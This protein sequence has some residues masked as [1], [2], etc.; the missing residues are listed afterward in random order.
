VLN[1][2][3]AVGASDNILELWREVVEMAIEPEEDEGY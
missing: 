2:L 3:L 1:C